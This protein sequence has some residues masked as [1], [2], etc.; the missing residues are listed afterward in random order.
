M[1]YTTFEIPKR[2]GL[3]RVIQKPEN[4]SS[5]FSTSFRF[6]LEDCAEEIKTLNRVKGSGRPR[7]Q[8]KH[9]N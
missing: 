3:T 8:A 7:L 1:K 5:L 4:G 2:N 6:L 9:G